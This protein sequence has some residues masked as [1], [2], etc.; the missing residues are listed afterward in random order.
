MEIHEDCK[1]SFIAQNPDLSYKKNNYS[2][3]SKDQCGKYVFNLMIVA[4]AFSV[5]FISF[6]I[7]FFSKL[8]SFWLLSASIVS[9]TIAVSCFIPA[10]LKVK[11]G[12]IVGIYALSQLMANRKRTPH[13]MTP[14]TVIEKSIVNDL[15]AE[16]VQIKTEVYDLM[17]NHKLRLTR[18]TY[19]RQ[20][21][22]IGSDITRVCDENNENCQEKGWEIFNVNIGKNFAKQSEQYLPSLVKILKHYHQDLLSC[23]ISVLP[24][25]TKI[26]PHV[27]YSSFVKR[28]MLGIEIP[29]NAEGC[30]LCV[31]GQKNVWREG[32]TLLWDDVFA[33]AVY[34]ETDERRIVI[35]MD[36]R[37]YSESRFVNWVGDKLLT[38]VSNS[39]II[40]KEILDTEKKVDIT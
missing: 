36:I 29:K 8:G 21:V 40:K 6:C 26:P 32:K 27:G 11:E 3:N 9:L 39:E 19:S 15:E 24:G 2:F 35:Y 16:Y 14:Q 31:N 4:L 1:K 34:N 13:V 10:Y 17:Q 25:K 23:V 18:D 12:P 7:A 5:L 22:N 38:L 37:R 20:N 28:L 30:Y 33:H